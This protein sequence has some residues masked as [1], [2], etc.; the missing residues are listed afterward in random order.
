MAV[1]AIS[2]I[3]IMNEQVYQEEMLKILAYIDKSLIENN[4]WYTLA[5]GSVLGAVRENGFIPWDRDADIFI[6][7]TEREGVRQVLKHGL[8]SEW[9]YLDASKDNVN[10]FDNIRSKEYGEFA[11]V[12]IYT[13]YG[14][15]DIDLMTKSQVKGILKRNKICTKVFGAKYGDFRKLRK[16]YK[17]VPYIITKGFLHLIPNSW[18]RG[19]ITHYEQKDNFEASPF[20]MSMVTYRRPTDIMPR[21]VFET[22]LRHQFENIEVNIPGDYHTYLVRSYGEDYMTPKQIGWK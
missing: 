9:E 1:I 12:D 5:Y 22:S 11:Q 13:L 6:K 3:K 21:S 20:L 10:C 14:A 16:K 2:R 18:I 7:L 15:P 4:L 8:P 19:I 17:I